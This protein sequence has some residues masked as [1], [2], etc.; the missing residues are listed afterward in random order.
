MP[1]VE[2]AFVNTFRAMLGLFSHKRFMAYWLDDAAHFKWLSP[3]FHQPGEE[4]RIGSLGLAQLA[5]VQGSEARHQIDAAVANHQDRANL[6]VRTALLFADILDDIG[7]KVL[8]RFNIQRTEREQID[9][10]LDAAFQKHAALAKMLTRILFVRDNKDL[11]PWFRRGA[12][13]AAYPHANA[14]NAHA[15]AGHIL[16]MGVTDFVKNHAPSLSGAILGRFLIE[17]QMMT[18]SSAAR[19]V[20]DD[21]RDPESAFLDEANDK[22]SVDRKFVLMAVTYGGF[23]VPQIQTACAIF[24]WHKA[25]KIDPR[26]ELTVRDFMDEPAS[27]EEEIATILENAWKQVFAYL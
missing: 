26:C 10:L 14:V 8:D 11:S 21:V 9:L 23:T 20:I 3:L 24:S 2:T 7:R 15:V 6:G 27:T 17:L 18:S 16:R 12:N 19:G 5:S 13:L 4:W 25:R 22:L 1:F